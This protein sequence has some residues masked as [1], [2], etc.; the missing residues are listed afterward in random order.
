MRRTDTFDG[1]TGA[2]VRLYERIEAPTRT[3]R[4]AVEDIGDLRNR[5]ELLVDDS[6]DLHRSVGQLH[7][8]A[9]DK[10]L[11]ALANQRVRE[12]LS[13]LLEELSNLGFSWRDIARTSQ[14]SVPALRKWRLGAPATGENRKRVADFLFAVRATYPGAREPLRQA[15]AGVMRRYKKD[16][17]PDQQ[18][19]LAELHARFEDA[20][21]GARLEQHVGPRP[22]EREGSPDFTSLAVE[23][24]AAPG[25]LAEYWPWLTSGDAAAAWELGAALAKADPDGRLSDSL[26]AFAGSGPDLRIVC[27][28]VATRREV[29]G[30]GW[31]QQW[32][33]SQ[34]E[35]HPQPVGLI[36]EVIWRCGVTDPLA[37]MMAR[38][39]RGQQVS[40]TVVGQ[41]TYADWRDTSASA[42]ESVLRAMAD[43]GHADTAISVLQRR[44]ELAPA[45]RERWQPFALELVTAVDLIRHGGMPS[46][47]WQ[48]VATVLVDDYFEEISTAI[49]EAHASRD[50]NASWFMDTES[51]VAEVLLSCVE[52]DPCRVWKKL[53]DHLASPTAP[54]GSRSGFR[55][56]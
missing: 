23:L 37:A 19:Q 51:A 49:F 20:A 55:T 28:Y 34:S 26:P 5:A 3:I 54:I 35:R 24:V 36:F 2:S 45:E 13:A 25:V 17:P 47:Y 10:Q 29:L 15:V 18:R 21:L 50:K 22:W 12:E 6:L 56:R 8:E 30:D 38:I 46:H 33:T 39:L 4:E 52:R 9:L 16:L 44:M 1:P 48:Q 41:V 53:R 31:Y 11:R 40:R 32:V 7:S 14:V 43:T 27:G 42:L